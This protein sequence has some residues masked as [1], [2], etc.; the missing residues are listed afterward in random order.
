MSLRYAVE[1]LHIATSML[2]TG[3]GAITERLWEVWRDSG[4]LMV[5]KG[6]VPQEFSEDLQ[7]VQEGLKHLQSGALTTTEACSDLARR[8][9]ALY[10]DIC[11]VD[12]QKGMSDL[13]QEP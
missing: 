10:D 4:L 11:R 3:Q 12:A 2:A 13:Y 5:D 9:F 1:K 8:I 6:D 7:Q